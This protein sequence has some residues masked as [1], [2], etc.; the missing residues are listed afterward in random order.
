MPPDTTVRTRRTA[1]NFNKIVGGINHLHIGT[2]QSDQCTLR[3]RMDNKAPEKQEESGRSSHH[4]LTTARSLQL[5]G[6]QIHI[7]F[8][9]QSVTASLKALY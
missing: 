3:N 6:S 2:I 9:V 5:E 1:G 7:P 4:S 8:H